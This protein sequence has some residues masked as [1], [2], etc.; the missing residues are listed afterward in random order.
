MALQ[1]TPKTTADR[2]KRKY[3]Q[4]K[5]TFGS[6]DS[7][8]SSIL[9]GIAET[10][11]ENDVQ[12]SAENTVKKTAHEMVTSRKRKPLKV[13]KLST[14]PGKGRLS[15]KSALKM[16]KGAKQAAGKSTDVHRTEAF[17]KKTTTET[18][19]QTQETQISHQ[20]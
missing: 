11:N 16:G 15:T 2:V 13:V 10:L 17:G 1:K 7:P 9:E 19:A 8:K 14:K 5:S 18:R 3:A 12:N 6:T 4:K 20:K